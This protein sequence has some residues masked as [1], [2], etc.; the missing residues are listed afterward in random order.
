MIHIIVISPKT[1]VTSQTG[2]KSRTLKWSI[3]HLSDLVIFCPLSPPLC[4]SH[5]GLL[6]KL[7]CPLRVF[8]LA[9]PSAWTVLTRIADQLTHA[10]HISASCDLFS[11]IF[12]DHP[13]W[14]YNT[15][16]YLGYSLPL[17]PSYFFL[18]E[19]CAI[20]QAFTYFVA[21]WKGVIEKI[22]HRQL[23]SM[24]RNSTCWRSWKEATVKRKHWG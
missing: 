9:V 6:V 20:W 11:K 18:I 7:W 17:T 10:F 23:Y 3:S 5:P 15:L 12:P 19:P 24:E 8:T 4:S 1:P 21:C 22:L 2:V 13:V 14:S 16:P